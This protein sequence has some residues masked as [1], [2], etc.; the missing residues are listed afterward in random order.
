[1]QKPV[2]LPFAHM[3]ALYDSFGKPMAATVHPSFEMVSKD[4]TSE[5]AQGHMEVMVI[6]RKEDGVLFAKNLHHS[7][8]QSYFDTGASDMTRYFAIFNPH[9]EK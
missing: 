8:S 2:S 6:R 7:K 9:K 1:M 5:N 3:T 4:R